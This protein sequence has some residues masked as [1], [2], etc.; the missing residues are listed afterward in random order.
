MR[1]LPT[2]SLSLRGLLLAAALLLSPTASAAGSGLRRA[3]ELSIQEQ[4][5]LGLRYMKRGYYA[6]ALETFNRIRNYHRDDPLAV[7][8]ELAVADVYYRKS[9]WDQARLAYDDFMRMHP[10]NPDLDYVTWR[11]GQSLYRKAPKVAARDQ[12]W[13]R[14]AVNTWSGFDARFADSQY[15]DDVD[16]RLGECRERLARKELL[17]AEFY[18]RRKAWRAV[19]GRAEGLVHTFPDSL[20]AQEAWTLLATA[21]AHRGDATTLEQA[22]GAV[23][24]RDAS[25]GARLRQ[26]LA[27]VEPV[28]EP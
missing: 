18:V 2:L 28:E 19:A 25:Q 11:M 16:R 7:K 1:L 22:L 26:K 8:A 20:A 3:K 21:S 9:E 27:H 5:E 14:Q 24:E 17:I 10:R 13:T 15:K 12:T 6:K 4:Y 23:S